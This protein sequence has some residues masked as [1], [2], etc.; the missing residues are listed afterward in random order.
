MAFMGI[1]L[2]FLVVFLLVIGASCI[3]AFICFLVS[4]LMPEAVGEMLRHA[5]CDLG[6]AEVWIGY[7]EGNSRSCRV[8]KKCGFIYQWTT[9]DVDVPIMGETRVGHVSLL[10]REAKNMV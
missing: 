2:T 1:F 9:P 5:F 6:M 10:T 8:Q 4:G 7:Y 3:V